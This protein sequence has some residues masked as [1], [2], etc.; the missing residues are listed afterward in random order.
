[1]GGTED[2]DAYQGIDNGGDTRQGLG[3]ILNGCHQA[4]AFG[5]LRQVDGGPYAQGQHNNQRHKD[6]KKGIVNGGQD[7][8]GIIE[9]ALLSGKK[10]PG[11]AGD[12]LDADIT[13]DQ[14]Q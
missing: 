4:A 3:G 14:Q 2:D 1:Q 10:L 5:V 13:D 6:N 9:D 12:T 8:H 7:T 11:N